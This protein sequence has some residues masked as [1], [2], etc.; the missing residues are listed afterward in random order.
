M[1]ETN[2][3]NDGR[4][5]VGRLASAIG[6]IAVSIEKNLSPGDVA[7]LRR[8]THRD[9]G[10]PAFWKLWASI[11][12]PNEV[13]A[14]GT[15]SESRQSRWAAILGAMAQLGGL[16]DPRIRLGTALAEAGFSELRLV[17]LLR[18]HESVLLDLLRPTAAF[19]SSK[20]V[21][22]NQAQLAELVLSD[23][24]PQDDAVRRRIARDF[25]SS[26]HAKEA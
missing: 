9:P 26:I 10:G 14:K 18:A 4:P 12:E 25:Y 16:H 22:C 17:R 23:G 24:Q 13:F 11:I 8:L 1:T 3:A 19:L 21:S 5:E 20:G 6:A 7:E 15:S 2:R